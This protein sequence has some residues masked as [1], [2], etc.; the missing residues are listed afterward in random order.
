MIMKIVTFLSFVFIGLSAQSQVLPMVYDTLDRN[1]EIILTGG[2]QLN[3]TSISNSLTSYFLKGGE[4]PENVRSDNYD[5]HSSLNRLGVSFNP[6]LS[7][8]NYSVRLFKNKDWGILIKAGM[9]TNVSARYRSGLFGLAFLGNEPF[10]G[11]TVDLSNSNVSIF[12]AQKIGFGFID[13]LSKSSVNLNVYGITNYSYG[14]LNNASLTQDIDGYNAELMLKG[15]FETTARSTYFKGIGVGVDANFILPIDAFGK[16]SFIQFQVQDLG[17]GF[18]TDN[19]VRY[20]MDTTIHF[21]GFEVNDF[22]GDGALLKNNKTVF[23]EIGLKRDTLKSDAL[24]LPFSI[25][26]AKIIDEHNTNLLQSYFGMQATYQKG[27]IPLVYLGLQVRPIDWLRVG[28]SVSYGGFSKFRGG[29]YVQAI[30][31]RF[32]FGVSTTNIVGMVSKKGLGQG[33]SLRMNYRL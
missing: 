7:Y 19:I 32:N 31:D 22:V 6:E 8:A 11:T 27:A 12:G 26:V 20:S 30:V 13:A 10:L 33:Y 23:D 14:F 28:A 2:I 5:Q 15:Q 16:K 29:L 17:I 18:L 1:Q 21:N 4:I 3:T 25:Q 24:A 9:A